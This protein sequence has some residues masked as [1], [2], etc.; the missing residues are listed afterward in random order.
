VR[1]VDRDRRD[2][3]FFFIKNILVIH[4]RYLSGDRRRW[5]SRI[6]SHRRQSWAEYGRYQHYDG[7]QRPDESGF[8][9]EPSPE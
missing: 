1:A 2:T 5:I 7:T 6:L 8:N 3:I 4:C 9:S